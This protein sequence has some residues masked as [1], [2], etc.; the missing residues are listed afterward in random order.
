MHELRQ[1][2]FVIV[3][4]TEWV[5]EEKPCWQCRRFGTATWCLCRG[6]GIQ[7]YAR[8]RKKEFFVVE[9]NHEKSSGAM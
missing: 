7:A 6:T 5:D 2:G 4:R 3:Y 9:E 8:L 1:L